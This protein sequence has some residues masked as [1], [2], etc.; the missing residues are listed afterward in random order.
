MEEDDMDLWSYP[1]DATQGTALVGFD[2]VAID[3]SIGKV[4]EATEGA[5]ESSVVVDT[6]FWIF[7]KKRVIPAGVIDRVDPQDQKIYLNLTKDQVKDAP[8]W[9]EARWRT[10]DYRHELGDYYKA[11]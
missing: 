6:G 3:G 9:D 11:S 8:D 2:V 4:D 7:G 1:S 5:G 10:D